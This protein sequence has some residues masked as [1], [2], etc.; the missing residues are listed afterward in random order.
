MR[1]TSTT[2]TPVVASASWS[3][4]RRPL[5]LCRSVRT[6][7]G[8]GGQRGNLALKSTI[9]VFSAL[10]SVFD[11]RGEGSQGPLGGL[12]RLRAVYGGDRRSPGE[13]ERL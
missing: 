13:I 2:I 11:G 1:L 4:P 12:C 3:V 9:A 7:S 6:G 10:S 8:E 5:A